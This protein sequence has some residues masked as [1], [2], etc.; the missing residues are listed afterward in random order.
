MSN[1]YLQI[2]EKIE[3]LIIPDDMNMKRGQSNMISTM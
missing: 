2:N 1:Q 3:T